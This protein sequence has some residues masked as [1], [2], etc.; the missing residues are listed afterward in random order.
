M[1]A[2]KERSRFRIVLDFLKRLLGGKPS[3]PPGDPYAYAIAPLRV[4]QEA[5]TARQSPKSRTT[6][7]KAFLHAVN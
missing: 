7:S 2:G 6:R 1:D 4:A 5:A 3:S